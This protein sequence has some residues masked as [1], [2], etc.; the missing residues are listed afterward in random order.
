MGVTISRAR[1]VNVVLAAVDDTAADTRFAAVAD[2]DG[3]AISRVRFVDGTA[4]T[5]AAACALSIGA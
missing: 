1:F 3:A 4:G 5:S 2:V